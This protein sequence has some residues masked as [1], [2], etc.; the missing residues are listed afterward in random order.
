MN[1]LLIPPKAE[2]KYPLDKLPRNSVS[3]LKNPVLEVKQKVNIF[4]GN[5]VSYQR[6]PVEPELNKVVDKVCAPSAKL[7]C[8]HNC[9]GLQNDQSTSN[10]A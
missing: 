6:G 3:R 5:M 1:D 7:S 10:S 9:W 4:K 2:L 8:L